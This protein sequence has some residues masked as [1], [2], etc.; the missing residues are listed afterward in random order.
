MDQQIIMRSGSPLEAEI[1]AKGLAPVRIPFLFNRDPYSRMRLKSAIRHH[2]PRAVLTWMSRATISCP[3]GPYALIARL[4]GYYDLKYYR[5]CDHLVANTEDIASYILRQGWPRDKV[6]YLPNFATESPVTAIDRQALGVPQGAPLLV[7]LGRLHR[8]KAFDILLRA[9]ALVDGVWLWLAGDG[10]LE[11][12]LKALA[13]ELNIAHRVAF[14]G[15]RDDSQSLLAAADCLVCPSRVEPL[16]NVVLEAWARA[17]PVVAAAAIGPFRLIADGKTGLTVPVEDPSALAEAIRLVVTDRPLAE[18][19]A[20]SG[21]QDYQAR[22]SKDA[23]V[24]Q[25]LEFFDRVVG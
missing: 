11:R 20:A 4:G 15:W 21:H 12:S 17:R 6:T 23:V 3:P 7:A 5:H 1:R 19:L 18:R 16:G 9:L 22:F 8:D 2:A 14:L 24:R 25:Y 10:P 13:A